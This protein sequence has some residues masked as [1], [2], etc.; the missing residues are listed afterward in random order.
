MFCRSDLHRFWR[1]S[2][3]LTASKPRAFTLKKRA[4]LN[5]F[6]QLTPHTTGTFSR[7][8]PPKSDGQ[9]KRHQDLGW[10]RLAIAAIELAMRSRMPMIAGSI[11]VT[12]LSSGSTRRISARGCLMSPEV[13]DI[14]N[15]DLQG[16][17]RGQR[18]QRVLLSR[19]C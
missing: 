19:N 14:A 13:M 18:D 15:P 1:Q 8:P 16:V 5:C 6:V 17:G 3:K 10:E 11:C 9:A 7:L 12:T 4:A 2:R